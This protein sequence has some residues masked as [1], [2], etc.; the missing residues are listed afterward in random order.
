MGAVFGQHKMSAHLQAPQTAPMYP[1]TNDQYHRRDRNSGRGFYGTAG[2][3]H[4]GAAHAG[5]GRGHGGHPGRTMHPQRAAFEA[6]LRPDHPGITS[7]FSAQKFLSALQNQAERRRGGVQEV[8]WELVKP[9]ALC[10]PH[11][12]LLNQDTSLTQAAPADAYTNACGASMGDSS[13]HDEPSDSEDA[14]APGLRRVEELLRVAASGA[15]GDGAA[16]S[17][18]ERF[19]LPLL[20]VV[21]QGG[22]QQGGQDRAAAEVLMQV[23]RLHPCAHA[24]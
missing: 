5:R 18:I 24:K 17:G 21:L 6:F 12:P 13:T 23:P 22:G 19:V 1:P 11:R 10:R 14:K 8:L 16:D 20:Q 7:T 3:G 2:P 4:A 9:P 15:G